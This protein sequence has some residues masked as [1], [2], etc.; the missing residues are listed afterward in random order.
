MYIIRLYIKGGKVKSDEFFEF[1]D[2]YLDSLCKSTQ[3]INYEWQYAPV[4]EGVSVDLLCPEQDAY[5]TENATSYAKN[6]KK[7]LE[8]E[9]ECELSFQN[10]GLA[11]EYV[12][13]ETVIPTKSNFFI[14]KTFHF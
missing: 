6:W 13:E 7:R 5:K 10:L 9:L 4:D 3:I 8:E 2:Y 12:S 11:P 14:L 1:A